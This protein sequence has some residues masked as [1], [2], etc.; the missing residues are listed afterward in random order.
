MYY[1]IEKIYNLFSERNYILFNKEFTEN[2]IKL[3]FC[4][5]ENIIDK[6]S[7]NLK[8]N[9]IETIIPLKNH[10]KAYKSK[11][12]SLDNAINY[13]KLHLNNY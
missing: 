1:E 12:N 7:I 8:E 9:I 4:K 3:E 2:I 5:P 13:L 11:N 6:Y 10:N